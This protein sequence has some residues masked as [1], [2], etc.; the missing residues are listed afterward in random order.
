MEGAGS[1]RPGIGTFFDLDLRLIYAYIG[2]VPSA[3]SIAL[4]ESLPASLREH[5]R[6]ARELRRQSSE[7]APPPPFATSVGALDR[8]LEGGLPRGRLV[9]LIGRKSCGRFSIVLST[10]ASATGAAE[11]TALVD[12]GDSFD[13][14][15]A[16]I[17]GTTLELLL[18]VR[19]RKLKDALIST[20]MLLGTGFPLVILDLGHPPVPGG[21]GVE[22]FWLRLARAASDRHAALL[23]SS[24]YRVSG[25]AAAAVV[26]ATSI[27]P[28]WRGRKTG[29]GHS[30]RLL[31]G[32]RSS[33]TLEKFNGQGTG[34]PAEPLRFMVDSPV[35]REREREVS[36]GSGQ[37]RL[38]MKDHSRSRAS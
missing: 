22:A 15:A 20:E 6:T 8:L 25:T 11:T 13:P 5:L 24:P 21:R 29:R 19:P 28:V 7:T 30:S 38:E 10:L 35:A 26:R 3:L 32:C 37:G 14:Q 34:R 4:P 1:R 12:L 31:M 33:L 2:H 9:E 17:A 18:W 36:F 27:R 16:E 23:V